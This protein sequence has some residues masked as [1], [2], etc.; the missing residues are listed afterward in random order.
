MGLW[1]CVPNKGPGGWLLDGLR[2]GVSQGRFNWDQIVRF[3]NISGKK[4]IFLSHSITKQV[5][6]RSAECFTVIFKARMPRIELMR[7]GGVQ[8]MLPRPVFKFERTKEACSDTNQNEFL[9]SERESVWPPEHMHMHMY[10]D[11]VYPVSPCFPICICI[12]L[13]YTYASWALHCL[14]WIVNL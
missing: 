12:W 4:L 8:I 11:I 6:L 2:I 10:T 1:Q 7:N 13:P 14:F 9:A 3:R 5:K